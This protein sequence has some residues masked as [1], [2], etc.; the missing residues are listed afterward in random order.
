MKKTNITPF[1]PSANAYTASGAHTLVT[2]GNI[3]TITHIHPEYASPEER[4]EKLK[5]TKNICLTLLRNMSATTPK[6]GA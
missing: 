3:M 1:P 6:C 4:L 2:G 5:D